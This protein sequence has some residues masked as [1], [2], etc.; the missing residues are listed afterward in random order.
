MPRI[1]RHRS[2]DAARGALDAAAHSDAA[3][4]GPLR[5][6][7]AVAAA[8]R[9]ASPGAIRLLVLDCDGVLT[10]GS[11]WVDGEGREWKSFSVVDG[12]GMALARQAGLEIA[13]V[14]REAG[15]PAL[16]RARKLGVGE[17]RCGVEK[18]A[19][20]VDE[21]RR[22]RGLD[23]SQVAYVGDDLPDVETMRRCGLAAAPPDARATVRAAAHV[24]TR[25]AAG[26]G[27][28]REVIDMILEARSAPRRTRIGEIA[29]E[30]A[31]VIAE[32]G[33]NHQGDREIAK[34]LIRQAKLCG[35]DAVKSQ[36]RDAR[37]LLTPEEYAQP[38]DS[39]HAFGR[40]YGEHREALELSEDA[41]RELGAFAADL[42]IEIFGSAWDLPSARLLRR[43]GC[44]IIKVPS[45][46]VTNEALLA[47]LAS[48]GLPVILSTG[49]SSLCEIDRAVEVLG[50]GDLYLLQCTS[51]YPCEFD[52]VNLRVI[53]A[54]AGRYGRT[55]GLSGHHKGIAIDVAAVALGARVIERHFTLDRTWKGTDHAASLEPPGL[56]RLVR[57]LRAVERA[58]GSSDKRVLPCEEAPRAKLRGAT[59]RRAA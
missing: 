59:M 26:R 51:A 11:V 12:H 33:N 29:R 28:V 22:R 9:V 37:A 40:T 39:P 41:W 57:D 58:M 16:A 55:V 45:A 56:A 30:R 25:S 17:V 2:G 10:D 21:I 4:S 7:T 27:A 52:A 14:T 5:C 46:A 1:P 53:P 54:L 20:V 23:W 48:F 8:R 38:Y 31:Y 42:G 3:G 34:E 6:G 35:A 13:I 36:K 19:E 43:L 24:V 47:E 44:P 15:G 18:K 32:I 49:M 50:A